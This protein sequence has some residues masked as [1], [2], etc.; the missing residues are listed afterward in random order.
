[1]FGLSLAD[2]GASSGLLA[3]FLSHQRAILEGLGLH[4]RCLSF[5]GWHDVSR[6]RRVMMMLRVLK[7]PTAELG[8]AA[9]AKFDCEAWLPGSASRHD[10]EAR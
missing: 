1:M 4:F 8:A 7:M 2:E 10:P 6:A 5:P 3:E 9:F